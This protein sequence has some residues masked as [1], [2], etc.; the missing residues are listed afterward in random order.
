MISANL[1]RPDVLGIC[2]DDVGGRLTSLC[3][4][5]RDEIFSA[6]ISRG[7]VGRVPVTCVPRKSC[8]AGTPIGLVLAKEDDKTQVVYGSP[9]Q[10]LAA[11][12]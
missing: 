8:H 3:R 9:T 5:A 7:K 6:D 11:A 12:S 4:G 1:V 2:D 10:R